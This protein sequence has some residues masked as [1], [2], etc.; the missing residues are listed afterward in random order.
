MSAI[1]N[2]YSGIGTD[3]RG[4]SITEIFEQDDDWL[5]HTHDY[6]Q[7]LFPL[8][9][10]SGSNARAPILDAVTRETFLA[11]PALRTRMGEALRRMLS[12]YGL[13]E[14]AG[15]IVKGSNWN[16]RKDNWFTMPT[17]NDLRITRI[18]RSLCMLGLRQEATRVLACL[19]RLAKSEP[20]CGT[21]DETLAYWRGTLAS[22]ALITE[23]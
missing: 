3:D 6:I 13:R 10:P 12:F 22:N 9:E 7:W 20:D 23:D 2:Y 8:P 17:H 16:A 11:D 18:L 1:L 21:D 15:S 19:Q 5:E 4:R 14:E